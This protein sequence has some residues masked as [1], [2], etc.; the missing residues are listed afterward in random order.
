MVL[1]ATATHTLRVRQGQAKKYRRAAGRPAPALPAPP[2]LVRTPNPTV[3]ASSPWP[4]H[5]GSQRGRRRAVGSSMKGGTDKPGLSE[6]LAAQ[7]PGRVQISARLRAR[8][9]GS[10]TKMALPGVLTQHLISHGSES[11]ACFSR[12]PAN[13]PGVHAVGSGKV[14]GPGAHHASQAAVFRSV[15]TD[16]RTAVCPPRSRG[17]PSSNG[18]RLWDLTDRDEISAYP[19]ASW[20]TKVTPLWASVLHLR[21]IAVVRCASGSEEEKGSM[22]VFLQKHYR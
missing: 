21:V 8:L 2:S 16:G 20:V 13:K 18:S 10:L 14:L 19:L 1:T 12:D 11:G 15:P 17:W 3:Q 9:G 4:P 22:P 5:Q 6:S 7:A